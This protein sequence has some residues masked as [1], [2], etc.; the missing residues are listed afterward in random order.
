MWNKNQ[1]RIRSPDSQHKRGLTLLFSPCTYNWLL[2][3]LF[4]SGSTACGSVN[5][6]MQLVPMVFLCQPAG[7]S[8]PPTCCPQIHAYAP[9]HAGLC[10]GNAMGM[11][12][13]RHLQ[14]PLGAQRGEAAMPD[15]SSSEVSLFPL[16]THFL[17]PFV[18]PTVCKQIHSFLQTAISRITPHKL[19]LHRCRCTRRQAVGGGGCGLSCFLRRRR[20]KEA[21]FALVHSICLLD[22]FQGSK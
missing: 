3:H 4:P 17:T 12:H 9:G 10:G 2:S 14:S 11:A 19:P 15:S 18:I 16:P 1:G 22:R 13:C 20:H 8:L 7:P 21:G 5:T 6:R